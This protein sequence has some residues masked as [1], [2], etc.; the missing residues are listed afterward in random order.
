MDIQLFCAPKKQTLNWSLPKAY[1]QNRNQIYDTLVKC[2]LHGK[3]T[4]HS[5]Q[6]IVENLS[7]KL[8]IYS[9]TLYEYNDDSMPRHLNTIPNT[10]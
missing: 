2:K 5:Q 6:T 8:S 7:L 4:L 1:P 10:P 9:Q 3:Y